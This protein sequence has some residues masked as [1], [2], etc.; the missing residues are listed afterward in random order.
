MQVKRRFGKDAKVAYIPFIGFFG[1]LQKSLK[2][3]GDSVHFVKEAVK[4]NPDLKVI[5]TNIFSTPLLV[6]TCP[7]YFKDIMID[8]QNYKKLETLPDK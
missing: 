4:E 7:K 5:L 8:H 2:K 3:H 1:N 6:F